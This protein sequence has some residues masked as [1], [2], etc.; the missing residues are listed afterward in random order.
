MFAHLPKHVQALARGAA[1]LFNDNPAHPSLRHHELED[2]KKGQH[3]PGS[4]SVSITMQYRAIYV[5]EGD[6]RNVW[7]WIG[8]HGDYDTFTGG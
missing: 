8:T 7:Y 5:P 2:T 4:F 6:G 1:K 3:V